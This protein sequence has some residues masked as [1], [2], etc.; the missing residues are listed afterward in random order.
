MILCLGG[1]HVDRTSRVEGTVVLGTSNPARTTGATGGVAANV[2]RLLALLGHPVAVASLVGSDRPGDAV[3]AAL[4]GDGVET[5]L[6]GR[7]PRLPTAEYWAVVD[8]TGNLVL[9]IADMEIYDH[10]DAAWLE[11]VLPAVES[12]GVVVVDANLPESAV[13]AVAGAASGTV[14]AD[15]VSVPKSRRLA[16][17]LGDIDVVFPDRA[18]AAVLGRTPTESSA[19]LRRATTAMRAAG[20]GSVVVSLGNRGVYV[21]DG[22]RRRFVPPVD[23]DGVV[24]VTGAGDALVAGY[25]HGSL[26]GVA[27]PLDAALA[28]ASLVVESEG[29]VPG[30]LTADLLAA[31][32][33]RL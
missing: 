11:S 26:L 7:H 1:A 30:D 18:E 8:G 3:I 25:V 6:V 21:D 5:S 12:A 27:D 20:A 13:A 16:G 14:L 29:S 9:G 4:A 10:L 2:A 22:A 24:D 19:G 15:P 31:R 32:M 28:A 23:P 17:A 33:G